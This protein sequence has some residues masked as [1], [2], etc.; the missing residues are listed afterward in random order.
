MN[1]NQKKELK[2]ILIGYRVDE[3][4]DKGIDDCH[5]DKAIDK[6]KKLFNI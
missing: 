1:E 4:V 2:D 6:I 5:L 3:E